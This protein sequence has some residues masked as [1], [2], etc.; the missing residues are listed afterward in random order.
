MSLFPL[1]VW[2]SF[3]EGE[4]LESSFTR[5]FSH[6][7]SF[8]WCCE[9]SLETAEASRKSMAFHS[10]VFYSLLLFFYICVSFGQRHKTE[11]K[12][13]LDWNLRKPNSV[14][15]SGWVHISLSFRVLQV[16]WAGLSVLASNTFKYNFLKGKIIS[17]MQI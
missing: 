6:S 5:C 16:N 2:K 1:W 17:L 8:E 10:F 11:P 12:N 15:N 13:V 3:R 14:P 9:D 4:H 7:S